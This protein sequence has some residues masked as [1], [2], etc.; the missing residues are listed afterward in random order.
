MR[1]SEPEP[2]LRAAVEADAPRLRELVRSAYSRYVERIGGEPRPMRDDYAAVIASWDVT[3]AERDGEIIGVLCCGESGD[4]GG[5]AIDNVA[6]AP[7]WQGT[8]LGR[9]LLELAEE[10]AL[11]AGHTDIRLLTHETMVE[12]QALYRRAGYVEYE[13]RPVGDFHLMYMR[14]VLT[15]CGH[16]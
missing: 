13:R 8:G 1:S 10:R 2:V 12:N 16:G 6:V 9:R 11:A 5:F 14:K 3:V 4:Y 15:G 7:E